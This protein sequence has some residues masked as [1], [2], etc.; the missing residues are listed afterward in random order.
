MD[1]KYRHS[2]L[3]NTWPTLTSMFIL[4]GDVEGRFNALPWGGRAF[5][6]GGGGK[7]EEEEARP[8]YAVTPPWPV[9]WARKHGG[10]SVTPPHSYEPYYQPEAPLGSGVTLVTEYDLCGPLTTNGYPR[11]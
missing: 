11:I 6:S 10:P 3:N 4:D 5:T 9:C 2:L 8:A 1:T 7:E